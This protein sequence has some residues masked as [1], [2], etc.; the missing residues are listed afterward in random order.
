M[1]IL[2]FVAT[3]HFIERMK[4]RGI[5]EFLISYALAKGTSSVHPDGTLRSKLSKAQICEAIRTGYLE[6]AELSQIIELVVVTCQNRLI[7]VFT[8]IGDTGI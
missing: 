1:K 4:R 5:S 7:T 3:N 2:N 6:K 8:R